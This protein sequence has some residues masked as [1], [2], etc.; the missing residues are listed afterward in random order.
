MVG[1]ILTKLTNVHDVVLVLENSSLV[2]VD[3]QVVGC[4][5]NGHDTRESSSP[6]LAVHAVSSVLSF[7][8]ANN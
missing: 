2:V 1:G 8:C 5:E 4:A 6:G 3:V 7:V